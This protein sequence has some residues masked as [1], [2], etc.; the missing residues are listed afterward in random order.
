MY[1]L[2]SH[3]PLAYL[4]LTSSASL[5]ARLSISSTGYA[6]VLRK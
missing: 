4:R 5:I 3:F 6:P 1:H 2:L